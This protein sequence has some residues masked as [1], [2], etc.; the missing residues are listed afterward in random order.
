ARAL[1]EC[2][3]HFRLRHDLMEVGGTN[4]LLTLRHKNKVYWKLSPCGA[5]GMK[6]GEERCLR[7]F[8]VHRAT[9]DDHLAKPRLVNNR[10]IPRWRRPLRRIHLLDV[11]HEIHADGLTRSRVESCE[12]AGMTFGWNFG[13]DA[14]TSVA[15]Q[16]HHQI[17]AFT[18]AA[19]LR[20]NRWLA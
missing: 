3:L 14:E 15:Q 11:V 9:A 18:D 4:F 12:D 19:I 1:L 6:C 17:A 20:G 7:A 5:D 2:A 13:D 16:A 10:G 8:L